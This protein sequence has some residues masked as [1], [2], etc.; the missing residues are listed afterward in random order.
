MGPALRVYV[1]T[2]VHANESSLTSPS[3]PHI[4][5]SRFIINL[6]RVV[7]PTPG[8]ITFTD[9]GSIR[10]STVASFRM[11]TVDDIVGNIG[12]PLEFTEFYVEDDSEVSEH[13]YG[14]ADVHLK[15]RG[16][17]TSRTRI[18][19]SKAVG[20]SGGGSAGGAILE[21]VCHSNAVRPL[22]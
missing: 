11:P 13:V 15:Y 17:D 7:S 5:L 2:F 4:L 21:E 20:S 9:Q 10:L 12:E 14:N 6:R 8:P 22:D 16:E 18:E 19:N 1:F 3:L